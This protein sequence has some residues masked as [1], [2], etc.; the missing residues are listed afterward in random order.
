MFQQTVVTV[1]NADPLSD[2]IRWGETVNQEEIENETTNSDQQNSKESETEMT[3]DHQDDKEDSVYDSEHE[4]E[5]ENVKIVRTINTL[6]NNHHAWGY[7][8][9]TRAYYE[10]EH[11]EEYQ[12]K[13]DF[14]NWYDM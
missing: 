10:N 4:N 12:R 7:L 13:R 11:K 5:R 6:P 8:D 3:G 1:S 14:I 9:P 2:T